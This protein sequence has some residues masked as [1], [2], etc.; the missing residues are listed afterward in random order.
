MIV[1]ERPGHG[2]EPTN[3]ERARTADLATTRLFGMLLF[4]CFALVL[5]GCFSATFNVRAQRAFSNEEAIPEVVTDRASDLVATRELLTK[6]LTDT[7]Y[8]PADEWIDLVGLEGSEATRLRGEVLGE[9][10]YAS[11][12]ME[13]PIV[14]LY[15]I[16]LD[17]LLRSA[18][19]PRAHPA[20]YPS[21][22]DAVAT[23]T[24]GA[25]NLKEL[26]LRF[27]AATAKHEAALFDETKVREDLARRGVA[28]PP[29][30]P[31][32]PEAL[33]RAKAATEAADADAQA[34]TT[35]LLVAVDTLAKADLEGTLRDR[36]G[37][38]GLGALSVALRAT[39]EGRALI[40]VIQTQTARAVQSAE[41]EIFRPRPKDA[42]K[43][44]G[45]G[46]VAARMRGYDARS[47]RDALVLERAAKAVAAQLRVSVEDSPGYALRESI[48]DQVL[49]VQWDALHAHVRLDG[50]VLFYNQIGT[51]G[52]DGSYTGRTRRLDYHVAPIATLGGKIMLGFDWLHIQNAA[53]LNGSF[54]TDRIYSQNGTIT[55][56]GSLAQQLGIKGI[57]SD[58]ID[59]AADLI[60]IRTRVKNARFT[61][62]EV[63]EISVD[64]K[65]GRD[66]GVVDKAPLQVSFTQVDV[67]YDT[68]FLLPPE[69]TG[70]YWI[71]EILVGFRF[72]SYRLPRIVYELRDVSPPGAQNQNFQFQRE[73]AAQK[74]TSNYYMGGGTFR[75]GQ[76]TEHVVSLYG[77]VGV[78]GGAGATRYSFSA[79]DTEKPIAIVVDG[80]AGL[81]ARVRLTPRKNRFRILLEGQY[82]AEIVY[83]TIIESLR[84]V[85]SKN[86]TTYTVDRKVDF[87]S[88]DVFHGPRLQ[89]V[90][91]F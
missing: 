5:T 36:I 35:A 71:E 20:S 45:L 34:C 75:F 32:E 37:R 52:V 68:A 53:S 54:Q 76:G 29:F 27:E 88:T 9:S 16:H 62:G 42:A 22:L 60:G 25:K 7:P 30:A 43:E 81:G 17:R 85:Q 23:L 79:H 63:T 74:I 47:A 38:D 65:N 57:A 2:L 86:G 15:R 3:A 56:S 31:S 39:L 6:L 51:D 14:K 77:D 21:V 55:G 50:E 26:W 10:P 83:Q 48:V 33:T 67:A 58:V 61:T 12:E 78:Y 80:S 89:V 1:S 82:H 90:G 69:V 49:G 72:M 11:G 91:V 24:P 8:T 40:P 18:S 13:V 70:A 73:S 41:R 64:P 84:A 44:I 66:T 4:A 28:L 59:I 19:V 46:D 87:G